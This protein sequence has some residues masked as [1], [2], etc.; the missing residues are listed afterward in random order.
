[1]SDVLGRRCLIIGD[2]GAGKT[3]L[4]KRLLEE[5][6][7]MGLKDV[8][9]IDMAPRAVEVNGMLV[10]GVLVEESREGVRCLRSDDI[11]TPR[12][13]ASS[14]E[15]LLRLADHN[16]REVEKLLDSFNAEPTGALFVNDASIYLQRGDPDNLWDSLMRA[17]TVVAN[18]YMG[19]RLAEDRGTGL[20]RIERERMKELASK[21]DVVVRL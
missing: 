4:T 5:A 3:R 15:E 1:M 16:R 10:G 17:E 11:K 12:L 13:S 14:A 2:V 9:V 8:T 19:K 21:M 20:S 18:G 6:L 7:D